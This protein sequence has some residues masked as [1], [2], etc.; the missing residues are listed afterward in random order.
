MKRFILHRFGGV[1]DR[2]W[3]IYDSRKKV[4]ASDEY[5]AVQLAAYRC[6]ELNR[7]VK[8]GTI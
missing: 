6:R 2:T 4:Y 5:H 7:M 8:Y 3:R 1:R